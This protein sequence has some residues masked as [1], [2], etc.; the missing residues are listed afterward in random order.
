MRPMET[1]IL[2]A[3]AATLLCAT[4]ALA[5]GER[6]DAQKR[7]Q[8][9]RAACMRGE[10]GQD[11]ATCMREA[12]AALAESRRGRLQDGQDAFERNR[13]V[14]CDSLPTE[15]RDYC[16]RRMKGEGSVSGSVEGGGIIRE[17]RVTVP[18]R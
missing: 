3:F 14:R 5:A 11:R 10:G 15:D 2:A 6:S 9:D 12:G 17:L 18:A 4:T 1:S 13:A 16:I 7:Y 8:S